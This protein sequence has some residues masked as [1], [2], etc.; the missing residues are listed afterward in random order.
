MK[1]TLNNYTKCEIKKG[2]NVKVITGD[3]K[4]KEGMIA[5]FDRQAGK[6]KIA[7]LNMKHHFIKAKDDPEKVGGIKQAEGWIHISNVKLIDKKKKRK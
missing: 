7:G 6:V 4:G 5:K 2:D 1:Q 3:E